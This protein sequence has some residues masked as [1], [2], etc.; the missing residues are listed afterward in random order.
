MDN[1]KRYERL[2]E[3][4][5]NGDMDRRNFLGLIGAA[6]AAYG[7]QTPFARYANAQTVQQ[8]RFD[9]W[10]GVVSEAFRKHA[11]DPYTAATGINV[12]DGTFSGGDEYLAQVRSSQEG[13]FNIAHLSGVFDYARYV[14]FGLTVELNT[15]NIPN[16]AMVMDALTDAYRRVTP[17]Y[18]SAVPYNYGTTGLAYNRKYIS[19][20]EMKEKGA[21]IL[22]D[23]AY[24]DKIGGWSDW[25]TRIW[26][27]AL[28]TDQD[29]N[30]I[31]DMDAVWDAIRSH[32]DLALKYWGSGA[33]LMSLLAEEEIYVTEGWSGR[34]AALQEQGHD[35]GYYDPPNGFGW[36][37]CLFVIKGSPVEACE[38]LLNFML[39]PETSIAVAEGQN[40]PPALDGT[41]VDLGTKIPT[42]PAYDPT[43]TLDALTFADPAYWNGNEAEWSETFSRVQRGF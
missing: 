37:E 43:G 14:N 20:E 28:Q 29:P 30:N 39:A 19:D 40:Y 1:T 12:V 5:R 9:G 22:I 11:F 13:E 23:E 18:L 41:K 16:M 33:E 34:I 21:S 32:R 15:D 35:I 2:L 25:R 3:R 8:V 10:G 42:L 6:G 7:L 17:D 24:K 27:G 26:Y 38:E 4:Y 31:T 36:Q